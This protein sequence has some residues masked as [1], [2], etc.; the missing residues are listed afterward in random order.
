MRKGPHGFEAI[1][2]DATGV[3]KRFGDAIVVERPSLEDIVLLTTGGTTD[4]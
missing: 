2:D 4:A 3:K 1:T